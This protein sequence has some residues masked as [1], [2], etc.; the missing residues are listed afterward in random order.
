MEGHL[1]FITQKLFTLLRSYDFTKL[2]LYIEIS[3][4]QLFF[5]SNFIEAAKG[6]VASASNESF[7]SFLIF[8]TPDS[9]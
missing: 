2:Y 3:S 6:M 1:S 5:I 9:Y 4:P 8:Q 7:E